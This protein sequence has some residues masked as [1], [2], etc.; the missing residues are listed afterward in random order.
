MT[1]TST[2][3]GPP[4][5][6]RRRR[7]KGEGSI[8]RLPDGRWQGRISWT[9]PS[10]TRRRKAVYGRTKAEVQEKLRRLLT[11]RDQGRPL[12]GD[13]RLTVA[14]YLERWLTDVA[15]RRVRPSTLLRYRLDV[16]RIS[17]ALGR[18]RLTQLSSADVQRFLN[19]LS[20]QGLSPATVRHC[21]ATLRAAL[22]QAVAWDL[23]PQNPAGGKRVATPAV[24]KARVPAMTPELAE[25]ILAAVAGTAV[26]GPV[27]LALRTGMR[28]G[29]VLGVSWSAIDWERGTLAVRQQLQRLG[30]QWRLT[31]PKSDRSRRTLPLTPAALAVLQAERARQ[32]QARQ[33][34]GPLWRPVSGF[35]DLVFTT[36]TGR[37]RDPGTV[38]KA[39]Q[40]ALRR[41]GLPPLRFHDLRHGAASL[42]VAGGVPLKVVSELLGHS[43]ITLTADTYSHLTE[44]VHRSALAHLDAL[45]PRGPL[46]ASASALPPRL[47]GV[48]GPAGP[49]DP[50]DPCAAPR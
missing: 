28:L 35:E 17:A 29:E 15:G 39:F 43:S 42:L 21:R 12:P 4:A 26:E 49:A 16:Q 31:P 24:P 45:G 3:G 44:S 22:N 11:Q 6:A 25:A 40:A 9:D 38:T 41:A 10:G 34:A 33:A 48:P 37:P 46:P 36:A 8:T 50:A 18:V 7:G 2:R 13:D 32:V 27:G 23:I 20:D 1:V 30:G 19:G 14:A 5:P 47:A